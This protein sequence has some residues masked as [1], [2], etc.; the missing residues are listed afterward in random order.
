M[1]QVECFRP[2]GADVHERNPLQRNGSG[3]F[4]RGTDGCIETKRMSVE[5]MNVR[6]NSC[7][8]C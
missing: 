6:S 7:T 5:E 8:N 1:E 4:R 2:L 3:E